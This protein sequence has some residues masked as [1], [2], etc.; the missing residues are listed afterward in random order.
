MKDHIQADSEA[1]QHLEQSIASGKHWYIALL[2]AIGLWASSEENYNG[3]HYHYLIS[4]EAF[5]WLLL[6]ERLCQT[7]DGLV[8]E[9]EKIALFRYGQPPLELSKEK[10]RRLIGSAKYR[11]YLNYFYGVTV[12]R[13]LILAIEEEIHKE[14]RLYPCC[15][16]WRAFEDS[17]Q[18]IYGK[19]QSTL[20]R[21]FRAEKGYPQKNI[22][23]PTELSEFIYWL[24]KYRLSHSD[25]A[26][27]ASDTKKGLNY[28]ERQR[29]TKGLLTKIA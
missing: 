5:D 12:E 20:L 15:Q 19:S 17:Y 18:R 1:I 24:F 3:R 22:I 29:P 10:F 7:V 13:A 23:D 9:K 28:L 25:R 8:P 21:Q 11:A 16:D 14:Q 6:A 2:E 4:G 27:L 26:R